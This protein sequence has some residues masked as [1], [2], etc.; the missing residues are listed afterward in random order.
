MRSTMILPV[1]L[2]AVGAL[3]CLALR[4]RKPPAT[5]GPPAAVA[6]AAADEAGAQV[7]VT[8]A[9]GADREPST[10]PAG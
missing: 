7:A 4:E 9:A 1:V 3:S 5:A 8:G 10:R 6:P 2:L